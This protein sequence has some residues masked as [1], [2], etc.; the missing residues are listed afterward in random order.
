MQILTLRK[1]MW[2]HCHFPTMQR[3][4]QEQ[5]NIMIW[6]YPQNSFVLQLMLLYDVY[7]YFLSNYTR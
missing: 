5:R 2:N 6:Y 1:N 7:M 3:S 4:L